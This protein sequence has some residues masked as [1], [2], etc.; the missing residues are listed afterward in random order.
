[1]RLFEDGGLIRHVFCIFVLCGLAGMQPSSLCVSR[2]FV[3][4][5]QEENVAH[6]AVCML[7]KP[8]HPH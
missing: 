1:M 6:L 8:T 7:F 3:Q 4:V 5:A 2:T